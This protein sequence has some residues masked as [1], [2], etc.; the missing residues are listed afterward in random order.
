MK[1]PHYR[2]DLWSGQGAAFRKWLRKAPDLNPRSA[3]R[4]A[5]PARRLFVR[6]RWFKTTTLFIYALLLINALLALVVIAPLVSH[7]P[8]PHDAAIRVMDEPGPEKQKA[9]PRPEPEKQ[10]VERSKR[11]PAPAVQICGPDHWQ[12]DHWEPSC[13]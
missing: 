8:K 10:K 13:K 12:K 6:R 1:K 3:K 2:T 7:A 5:T 9:E 11:Q 4:W